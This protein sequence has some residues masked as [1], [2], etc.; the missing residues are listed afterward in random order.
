MRKQG[1][2]D[3]TNDVTKNSEYY[4]L[5][6]WEKYTN[7]DESGNLVYYPEKFDKNN[8][9][10]K[11][12]AEAIKEQGG[13]NII[14][15]EDMPDIPRQG[16]GKT[17]G[18]RKQLEAR[19]TPKEYL[20]TLATD[21]VYQHESGMTPEDQLMYAITYLEENQKIMDD[22]QGK[23]SVSY[24]IGAYFPSSDDVP[25]AYWY[26]GHRQAYLSGSGVDDRVD[27]CGVRSAVRIKKS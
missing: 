1:G 3:P 22:Y 18:D 9:Q 7:A 25:H 11:T 17:V 12:K 4:P 26:R 16:K 15:I 23:G 21:P 6:K 27:H 14:L 10:G 20:Q 2:G 24:Q 8:H 19:S 5:W 13:W